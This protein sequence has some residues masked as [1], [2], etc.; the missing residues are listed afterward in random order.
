MRLYSD[1]VSNPIFLKNLYHLGLAVGYTPREF[2]K[3]P[4]RN[5]ETVKPQ[6]CA[7]KIQMRESRQHNSI[8]SGPARN[9]RPGCTYCRAARDLPLS[10]CKDS[11]SIRSMPQ[12]ICILMT[13][14]RDLIT[15]STPL[16]LKQRSR[17]PNLHNPISTAARNCSLL[18]SRCKRSTRW[19]SGFS[20][21][22]T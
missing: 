10:R 15:F 11:L 6:S 17:A 19:L 5:D 7:A 18:L 21:S 14:S 16:H 3:D 13:Y 2:C 8:T 20:I 9:H 1:V 22:Y 12:L 4:L